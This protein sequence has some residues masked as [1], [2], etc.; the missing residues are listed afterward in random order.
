LRL[1]EDGWPKTPRS[2]QWEIKIPPHICHPTPKFHDENHRHSM[3]KGM[4][5]REGE[6]WIVRV[7]RLD[8]E[9]FLGSSS[10]AEELAL[11]VWSIL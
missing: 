11:A 4:T 6:T 3:P 5:S 9:V 1:Q 7:D 10:E 8:G 2:M